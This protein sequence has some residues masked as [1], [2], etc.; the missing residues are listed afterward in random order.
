[1]HTL[2]HFLVG[3]GFGD[4]EDCREAVSAGAKEFKQCFVPYVAVAAHIAH[5]YAPPPADP[6]F[7]GRCFCVLP[8]PVTLNGLPIH[9]EVSWKLSDQ[10]QV[11]SATNMDL[12]CLALIYAGALG[13]QSGP[14][15]ARQR[16]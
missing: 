12:S 13:A 11:D 2:F 7:V 1:M 8:T 4:A 15:L 5:N 16:C 9:L 10:K 6:A 3:T 14:E